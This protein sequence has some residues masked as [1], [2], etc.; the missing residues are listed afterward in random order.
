MR[1]AEEHSSPRC[2]GECSRGPEPYIVLKAT[3]RTPVVPIAIAKIGA[4]TNYAATAPM[5]RID[6]RRAGG[7]REDRRWFAR[8]RSMAA[9][10]PFLQR[11]SLTP[12]HL[13]ARSTRK[14]T[15]S[16]PALRCS[17]SPRHWSARAIFPSPCPAT[18]RR[19]P[20]PAVRRPEKSRR[21]VSRKARCWPCSFRRAPS[22]RSAP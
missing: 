16:M 1:P 14:Q 4:A 7:I 12:R 17:F 3:D 5:H 19:L 9:D 21:R 20:M 15:R 8:G 10:C 11:N 22:P 2:S 6:K 13:P 18:R